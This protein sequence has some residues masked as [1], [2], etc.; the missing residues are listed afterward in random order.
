MLQECNK[1]REHQARE[2]LVETLEQQLDE[3][4]TAC[5]EMQEE[6]RQAN[7]AL[8]RMRLVAPNDPE[9]QSGVAES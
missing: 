8:A 2:I 3:R 4:L 6:I 9:T 1:F 5:R 7:E